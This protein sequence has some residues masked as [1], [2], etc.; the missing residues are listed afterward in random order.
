MHRVVAALLVCAFYVSSVSAFESF[1]VEDIRVEGARRIA[2]GT[3][4]NY[5]PV[6]VG[7]TLTDQ[8]AQE[9]IRA[10]FKTG[11]F[12]DIRL[13]REGNV[14]IV[15]VI[16]R[17]AIA[18][19][20]ITG[21]KEISDEDLKKSLRDVGFVEGRVF[22]RSLL[23]QIEQELERLY[24]ARGRYAVR[25]K[26]TVTPLE[27]NRVAV[28]L[29]ISEG[30][31]AK[32]REIDIVG[33][34]Q[35]KEKELLKLFNLQTK[36]GLFGRKNR[37]SRQELVG[38]LERLRNLYQDQGYLEF[39]I[40]S[41][42]VT[43]TPDKEHIYITVNI[44]EGKK[45]TISD[46]KLEGE[47][48]IPKEELEQLITVKRGDV[49]SRKRIT[50]I[51]N[52][53][54]DILGNIGYAFAN[55]NAI[56]DVDKENATVAF[57]FF[58]DPG[59]RVYVRRVTFSGNSSTRDDVLRREMRQLEGGWYSA[60]KIKRSRERLQRTGFF[61]SVNIE[62]P[63]VPGSPDQV[64]VNVAVKERLTGNLLFG[65]G[66][67]DSDGIVFN[68]SITESN[69]FGTGKELSI[70]LDTS[71]ANTLVRVR[72][73]NPY[74]RKS[75]LSRGFR[76][77]FT[78]I[79][80]ATLNIGAYQ[81]NTRSVGMFF[82]IPIS[83]IRRLNVGFDIDRTD[84][85]VGSDSAQVAK[86]FVDAN[87]PT[88]T[89][90]KTT[91]GWTQDSLNRAIF[92]TK[93][94]LQRVIGE[95]TVPGSELE[96]YKLNYTGS[97]YFPLGGSK[98]AR[99]KGE[100]GI[101]DGYGDTESLPFYQNFFAGGSRSVRGYKSRTLGPRDTATPFDPIGG[102]QRVLLNAEYIFPLPGAKPGNQSQRLSFFLDGGQ[103]FGPGLDSPGETIDFA[104][105]RYSIGLAFNWFSPVG[106]LAISVA[107]SLNDQPGDDTE[108]V[109]F[110]L[111]VPLR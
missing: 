58:V 11:F 6:K 73:V 24:F 55:V 94:G 4:F 106:P 59:K 31:T 45:F 72:Y 51:T 13:E 79:D 7:D 41:T 78:D 17:P 71:R 15:T 89:V 86:D 39:D 21:T 35:F 42:Q 80:T 101:G 10:L 90:L 97:R 49:F 5:L 60:A 57:T 69:L 43:I 82:G 74:W 32:I 109:Q 102:N 33:N 67:S 62:T 61:E 63:P 44:F 27:R 29:S 98:T 84:I 85:T 110:T 66:F 18:S 92:P 53:I 40:E 95:I 14:L 76:F 34:H 37:Y 93:G 28:D 19:I 36:G 1:V 23:G 81:T 99:V 56:P 3:V 105:L 91:L 12:K 107:A 65:V 52:A 100:I 25:I 103:V 64:D 22:N 48:V 77:V 2:P 46:V 38:D 54:T 20:N 16:E 96:Y 111:G 30:K 87:G 9:A 26:P 68:G 108:P 83:E 88:N 47:F 75:G 50:D 8:K 70:S 104:E